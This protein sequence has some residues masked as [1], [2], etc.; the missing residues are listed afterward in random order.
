MDTT[1]AYLRESLSNHLNHSIWEEI[2]KKLQANTNQNEMEF[3]RTLSEEETAF[4]NSVLEKEIR[5][6]QDEQDQIR[7]T[8]LNE[9]YELLI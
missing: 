9:V 4:L 2:Y 1:L 6:A 8:Q 7:V 5:Y 3:V